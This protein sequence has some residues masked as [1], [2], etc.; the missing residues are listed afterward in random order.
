MSGSG[1]NGSRDGPVGR[2]AEIR[3]L[4]D[5]VA[6]RWPAPS[7]RILP[8]VRGKHLMGP[9]GPSAFPPRAPTEGELERTTRLGEWEGHT[10]LA[11]AV[12]AV[13]PSSVDPSR[14]GPVSLEHLRSVGRLRGATRVHDRPPFDERLDRSRL[15]APL[16]R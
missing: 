7:C 16:T 12:D 8:V 11:A 2:L 4:P 14:A 3:A 9:E 1:S 6:E 10:Y 13:E 15:H 5:A